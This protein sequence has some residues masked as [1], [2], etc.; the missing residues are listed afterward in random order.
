MGQHWD[1]AFHPARNDHGSRVDANLDTVSG[2]DVVTSEDDGLRSLRTPHPEHS[3]N[4]GLGDAE[5][6]MGEPEFLD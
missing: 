3:K 4:G 6:S 2:E 5:V 1:R